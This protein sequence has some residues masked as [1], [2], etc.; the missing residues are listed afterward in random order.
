MSV[1]GIQSNTSNERIACRQQ[2]KTKKTAAEL[3][4]YTT[5]PY[6]EALFFITIFLIKNKQN[7]F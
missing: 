6:H 4:P 7:S 5:E 2:Q 3:I 1:S